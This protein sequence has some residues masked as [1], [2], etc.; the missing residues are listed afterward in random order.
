MLK[1]VFQ[2]YFVVFSNGVKLFSNEIVFLFCSIDSLI[3]TIWNVFFIFKA[4]IFLSRGKKRLMNW[5]IALEFH[6]YFFINNVNLLNYL[7][8]S[9]IINFNSSYGNILIVISITS[10]ICWNEREGEGNYV[11]RILLSN[12]LI[13]YLLI[14]SVQ[15]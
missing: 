2:K 12:Q 14:F 9:L 13:L 11:N 6:N 8:V 1:K 10:F 3:E 5:F 4:L 15:L 7:S